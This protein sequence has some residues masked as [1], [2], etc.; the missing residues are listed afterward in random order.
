MRNYL[1]IILIPC[2]PSLMVMKYIPFSISQR[3]IGIQPG[4]VNLILSGLYHRKLP[5]NH[6]EDNFS[7][8]SQKLG[9]LPKILLHKQ[10]KVE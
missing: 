8:L 1:T 9:L 4:L 5:H 6:T 7:I 3:C 10:N 2:R